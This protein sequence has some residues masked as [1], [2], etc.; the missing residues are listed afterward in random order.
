MHRRSFANLGDQV[1]LQTTSFGWQAG[2]VGAAALAL[3]AFFYQQ[4]DIG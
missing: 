2:A 1:R 4:L 3:D